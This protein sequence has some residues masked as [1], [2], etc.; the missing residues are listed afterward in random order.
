MKPTDTYITID[1]PGPETLF[2]DKN[3]KFFGYSYPIRSREDVK[4]RLLQIKKE[5]HAARHWCYAWQLGTE[6]ITYKSSDDGEPSNTAGSPIYGQ[7]QSYGVTNILI[8]VVRYFGGVKLGVGGLINAYKTTAKLTIEAAPL[9][10]KTIDIEFILSFEYKNMNTVMRMIKMHQ[11]KITQ[12][13]L[14]VQCEL[15]IKVRKGMATQAEGDFTSI[16]GVTIKRL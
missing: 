10:T 11:F 8:I 2:K 3:S 12:Q 16:Y 13:N 1:T 14:T 7:I 5:H 15:Y 4:A 6:E 9:L